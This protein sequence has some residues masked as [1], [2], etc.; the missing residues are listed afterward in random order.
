MTIGEQLK[1]LRESRNLTQSE[2]AKIL[3]VA[4]STYS[5]YEIGD[6]KLPDDLKTK[7][8][9]YY[10]VTIDYLFGRPQN[11]KQSFSASPKIRAIARSAEDVTEEDQDFVLDLLKKLKKKRTN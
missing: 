9:D 8:A 2:L 1:D 4:Q 3:G 7:I 11:D 6:R 5:Q 10:E